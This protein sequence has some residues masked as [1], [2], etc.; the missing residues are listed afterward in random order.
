MT[1]ELLRSHRRL[2]TFILVDGFR[3]GWIESSSPCHLIDVSMVS[4]IVDN[5]HLSWVKLMYLVV[6]LP[7]FCSLVRCS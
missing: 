6:M 3:K 1:A 7:A 2:S 5:G 4:V